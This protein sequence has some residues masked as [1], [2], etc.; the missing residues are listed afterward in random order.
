MTSVFIW[1][2]LLEIRHTGTAVGVRNRGFHGP[3]EKDNLEAWQGGPKEG[4]I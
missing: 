2:T 3:F 1:L 4:W